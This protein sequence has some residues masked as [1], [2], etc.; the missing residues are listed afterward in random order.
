MRELLLL[1]V[2]LVTYI[3]PPAWTPARPEGLSVL[4]TLVSR[5]LVALLPVGVCALVAGCL[6]GNPSY[7]PYSKPSD[8]G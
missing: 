3:P 4:R 7:F 6:S 5:V 8:D 1:S 2:A